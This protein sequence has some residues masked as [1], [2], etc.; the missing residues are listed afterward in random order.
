MRPSGPPDEP[1]GN[2][3]R[4]RLTSSGLTWRGVKRVLP[5]GSIIIIIIIIIINLLYAIH[6]IAMEVESW[7]SDG[8][9]SS[10][11]FCLQYKREQAIVVRDLSD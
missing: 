5:V 3:R 1:A 4:A 8:V 7:W 11:F 10:A 2:V 9:Q 6:M